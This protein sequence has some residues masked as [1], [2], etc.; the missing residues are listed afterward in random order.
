MHALGDPLQERPA[1][2]RGAAMV[3]LSSVICGLDACL[4]MH[5]AAPRRAHMRM[6]AGWLAAGWL[7]PAGWLAVIFSQI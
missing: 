2:W 5:A 7:L 4:I 6:H 3:R 1:A